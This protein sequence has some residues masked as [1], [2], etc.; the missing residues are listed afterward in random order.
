LGR[1]HH[2]FP[3]LKRQIKGDGGPLFTMSYM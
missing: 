1:L 2:H 3:A